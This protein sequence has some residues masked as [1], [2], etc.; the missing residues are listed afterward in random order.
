MTAIIILVFL[1]LAAA[2]L[3]LRVVLFIRGRND[4][5]RLAKVASIAGS[6]GFLPLI[7]LE[8]ALNLASAC[9]LI[10]MLAYSIAPRPVVNF[11]KQLISQPQKKTETQ[12]AAYPRG[13]AG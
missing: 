8:W 3:I 11:L 7:A 6:I 2:S 13:I 12:P 9:L 4:H 1:C 5:G 10:L